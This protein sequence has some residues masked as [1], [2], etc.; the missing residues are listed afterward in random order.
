MD[1][2]LQHASDRLLHAMRRR[3]KLEETKNL[4]KPHLI[5]YMLLTLRFRRLYAGKMTVIRP[6]G[7]SRRSVLP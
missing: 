6:G 4:L 2:P 1:L 7:L 5:L 3:D